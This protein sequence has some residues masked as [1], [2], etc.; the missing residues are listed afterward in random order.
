MEVLS[1]NESRDE[2]VR[3]S[4]KWGDLKQATKNNDEKYYCWEHGYLNYKNK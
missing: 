3:H 1:S 2:C 4:M